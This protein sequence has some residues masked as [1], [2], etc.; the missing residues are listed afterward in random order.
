MPGATFLTSE[1]LSLRTVEEADHEFVRRQANDHRIRNWIGGNEPNSPEDVAGWI[2]AENAVHF[3]PCLDDEPIGH[4][5][6]FRIDRAAGRAEI[7]Y[8]IRPEH[9]GEGYGTEAAERVVEYAFEDLGCNRVVARVYEGNEASTRILEGIGFQHEGTLRE[10]GY[11]GDEH[12]DCDVYGLL[13]E[14]R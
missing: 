6:L 9:Q 14:E 13:A 1:R 2:D 5:W 7:G 12:L 11:A 4:A 10:H 3:L 8:W